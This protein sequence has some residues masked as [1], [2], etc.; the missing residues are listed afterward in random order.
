[1]TISEVFPIGGESGAQ[2][3]LTAFRTGKQV[4]GVAVMAITANHREIHER[5]FVIKRKLPGDARTK[6][7]ADYERRFIIALTGATGE[8]FDAKST[9]FPCWM[10]NPS[11]RRQPRG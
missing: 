8:G 9:E 3:Q 4:S 6:V 5:R 11:K 1:M 10:Q 7:L 2:A